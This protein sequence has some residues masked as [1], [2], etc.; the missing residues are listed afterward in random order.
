MK[1]KRW[2]A[3][4][5]AVVMMVSVV[6]PTAFAEGWGQDGAPIVVNGDAGDGGTGEPSECT[7]TVPCTAESRNEQCTVCQQDIADC[8]A[9]QSQPVEELALAVGWKPVKAYAAYKDSVNIT[10]SGSLSGTT[11]DSVTVAITLS[12]AEAAL[13]TIPESSGLTLTDSD[14]TDGKKMLSFTVSAGEPFSK[15]LKASATATTDATQ[16]TTLDVASTDVTATATPEAEGGTGQTVQITFNEGA[17]AA[18]TLTFVEKLPDADNPYGSVTESE[19]SVASLTVTYV[20]KDGKEMARQEKAPTFTLWYQ[21]DGAGAVEAKEGEQLPFGLTKLPE[22]T[23]ASTDTTW[24]GSVAEG[25]TLPSKVL[26]LEG[27]TVVEKT[28]SWFLEPSYPEDYFENA[29]ALVQITEENAS[30]YPN[31]TVGQWYFIAG[32]TPYEDDDITITEK[33]SLSHNIYWADNGDAENKR[34]TLTVLPQIKRTVQKNP[35]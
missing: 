31:L 28:I 6:S 24:T 18:S 22:I 12:D 35:W 20:D 23:A 34:P 4:L 30:Q 19:G 8:K 10:V 14:A 17:T 25:T 9:G 3:M 15:T 1:F 11:A 27:D 16:L 13:L 7:C 5:M 26:A 32:E 29:G 21:V 2:I 33:T